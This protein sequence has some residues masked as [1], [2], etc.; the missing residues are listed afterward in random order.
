MPFPFR[1]SVFRNITDHPLSNRY[2]YPLTFRTKMAALFQDQSCMQWW[3]PND[4]LY[5]PIIRSIRRFV[6]ER[7]SEARDQHSEDLRDIKAIFSSMKIDD[8]GSSDPRTAMAMAK[9]KKPQL[10]GQVAVAEQGWPPQDMGQE[11][12][13][14][15]DEG[16]FGVGLG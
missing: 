4:E 2:I 15:G 11:D 8:G 1:A 14:V 12:L 16:H 3:L 5:P 9:G 10:E 7:T 13:G 6:E